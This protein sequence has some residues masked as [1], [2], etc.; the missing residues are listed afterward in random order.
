MPE[1][2]LFGIKAEVL[3][4]YQEVYGSVVGPYLVFRD[5]V[6]DTNET[7]ICAV[8]VVHDT[9]PKVCKVGQDECDGF[10][11]EILLPPLM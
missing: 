11:H 6:L 7:S 1:L 9:L 8:G 4:C 5:H 2:L 10:V 3:S